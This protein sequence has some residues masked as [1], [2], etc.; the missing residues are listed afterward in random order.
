MSTLK[1]F[2][3]LGDG[4][5]PAPPRIFKKT[6]R[7]EHCRERAYEGLPAARQTCEQLEGLTPREC[8]NE[9]CGHIQVVAAPPKPP[10]PRATKA[11]DAKICA[12]EGKPRYPSQ[13]TAEA[14]ADQVTEWNVRAARKT[15]RKRAVIRAYRC[16]HCGDWHLTSK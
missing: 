4:Q 7:C 2:Q 1:S 16:P 3:L 11:C 12:H 15:R 9:W 10:K 8:P 5:M 13:A 14:A 6:H